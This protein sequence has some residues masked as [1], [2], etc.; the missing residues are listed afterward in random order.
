MAVHFIRKTKTLYKMKIMIILLFAL[1]T[2][3]AACKKVGLC[4]DENLTLNKVEFT[5]T[6][7]RIDGFYYEKTIESE[8]YSLF[9]LYNNGIVMEPG[10]TKESDLEK[11]I[12][13]VSKSSLPLRTKYN[14][15][16]FNID[17]NIIKI[18]HWLPAQCGYPAVLRTGEILNDTTFILNKMERR[19]SQGTTQK[20]ITQTFLFRQFSPKP[21]STNNF[22]K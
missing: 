7:L 2:S 9:I 19:D 21:D 15:G 20:D 13:D 8:Y 22:I 10:S 5:G 1:I 18:E 17:D 4:K 14:W 6:Q 11:Y 12:L 16:L 3:C